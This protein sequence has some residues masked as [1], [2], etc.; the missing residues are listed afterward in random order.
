[1]ESLRR[2]PI[3]PFLESLGIPVPVWGFLGIPLCIPFL[4][5]LAESL[6]FPFWNPQGF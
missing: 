6:L 1:M 2:D 4:E 5:Y 3:V